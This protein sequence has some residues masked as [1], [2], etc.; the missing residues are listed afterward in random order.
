MLAN[1]A[2]LSI[3][4]PGGV[5]YGTGAGGS[6][7][8]S[9][10]AVTI[11]AMCGVVTTESLTTAAGAEQDITVTNSYV[12]STDGLIITIAGYSGAGSPIAAPVAI[13]DGTSFVFRI[14]NLHASNA[15]NAALT[16]NF[17]I[18]RGASA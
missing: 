10:N 12:K 5:G 7:T 13:T 16:V 9:S 17:H 4:K 14:T 2:L 3:I 8:C 15:L 11:N 6:G 18:I 1:D